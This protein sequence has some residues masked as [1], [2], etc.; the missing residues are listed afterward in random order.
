MLRLDPL[1]ILVVSMS[2]FNPEKALAA[3]AEND[4]SS[5]GRVPLAPPY[6]VVLISCS[7]LLAFIFLL[8]TCL[9]CKRGDVGFKEFE[10]PDGEEFSGEYTPPA[11][12]TSSSQSIPDVYILPLSEVSLPVSNTQAPKTVKQTGFSRQDL[13]YLQEIGNGW[14]GKVI[15]GEIFSDYTP[16]QVVVKELRVNASPLEQRKFLSEAQP[17]SLQ[18]SNILQCL[19]LCTETIPFLLIMEFCQLGDLKRYLRA[20]RKADGMTPDLLTCD[21]T[22]LQRMAYEITLGLMHL[23][24]NNYIHS[25]LA[26]RNC[27]LTS[28]L[29]VRIGDYGISHNNYKEDYY[30]T[31][32]RLWIPLR[33]VAP[34][35]LDEV[36]GNLVVVD[37]SKES[38]VWSLGV[39]MWELFEFGSQ[40]YRHLSDEEVLTFVIKEQQMKLAKPRLKLPHSDYWYEV[41][42]SCWLP[43]EQRPSVEELHLQL[44]YLLNECSNQT[45]ESFEWRWNAL[46]PT[47]TSG[48]PLHHSEEISAFPLLDNF[49]GGDGFHADMDDILTVTESSRG[50]NFEYM[51]EKARLG[52]WKATPQCQNYPPSNGGLTVPANPFYE[53]NH[54][55]S[56]QSLETPSVVPVISA[57]SPSVSSEY[58]IR[59]EE[60]TDRGNNVDCTV[61]A[62]SPIYERKYE[63]QEPRSLH[64]RLTIGSPASPIEPL[65]SSDWDPLESERT[66]PEDPPGHLILHEVPKLIDRW[67]PGNNNPFITV[68]RDLPRYMNPFRGPA[69]RD[70][71]RQVQETSLIEPVADVFSSDSILNVYRDIEDHRRSWDSDTMEERGAGETLAGDP[72]SLAE[73]LDDRASPWDCEPSLMED[74]SSESSSSSTDNSN[75]RNMPSCP[76]CSRGVMG[77]LQR[78]SCAML[79][80]DVVIDW[81]AHVAMHQDH[82]GLD[83]DS[84]LK[85]EQGSLSECSIP[86]RTFGDGDLFTGPFGDSLCPSEHQEF[87]DPLMGAAVKSYDIQDYRNRSQVKAYE[88]LQKNVSNHPPSPFIG[89]S[90]SMANCSVIVPIEIPPLSTLA[91]SME[92]EETIEISTDVIKRF[93]VTQNTLTIEKFSQNDSRATLDSVDSL[94]I[95]SNTSSSD[96]CSPSSHYSSP[97]QKFGDSGYETENTFSP[98][99]IFKDIKEEGGLRHVKLPLTPISESTSD[100]TLTE[101]TPE[102]HT[103][104]G[105]EDSLR[106]LEIGTPH[107]DSAYFSDYDNECEKHCRAAQQNLVAGSH[108]G[109]S[110]EEETTVPALVEEDTPNLE[111]APESKDIEITETSCEFTDEECSLQ[112][113]SM[114]DIPMDSKEETLNCNGELNNSSKENEPNHL[115]SENTNTPREKNNEKQTIIIDQRNEEDNTLKKQPESGFV[116]QV[117][118]EQLLVSLRENVT[119]NVLSTFESSDIVNSCVLKDQAVLKLW[120]METTA[121]PLSE[122]LLKNESMN[123]QP[124]EEQLEES[125]PRNSGSTNNMESA[126]ECGNKEPMDIIKEEP[127][128]PVQQQQQ[129]EAPRPEDKKDE[130]KQETFSETGIDLLE[131]PVEN[132]QDSSNETKE[133]AKLFLDFGSTNAGS[134][135]IKAKVARLSLSLPPLNLQAFQNPTG[136]KSLWDNNEE[137]ES[138][139]TKEE[140]EEEDG[141]SFQDQQRAGSESEGDVAGIPIVVSETDDGRNLRSLLKSPKSADEADDDLDRK[142]KM[143][144]FF[145][146]VT[147]YLFDQETPT[148]EL[149]NQS[150]A[151]GDQIPHNPNVD[152]TIDNFSSTDGFSGSF[153]WDDDFPLMTQNSSFIPMATEGAALKSHINPTSPPPPSTFQGKRVDPSLMDTLRFTRFTVSPAVDPHPVLETDVAPSAGIEN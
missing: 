17:Y 153:E 130:T 148:N 103:T 20:Q 26:L 147:V 105:D 13:S 2:Y 48:G 66:S 99:F 39:T 41:M 1:F 106:N 38:N 95:P 101:D 100:L 30:I 6:A 80:G 61:C 112:N 141:F 88:S 40:P 98:E 94:D 51:W 5:Q 137:W 109:F 121:N 64:Q 111:E 28:D 50:L 123:K 44:T 150:G 45:E 138:P 60:H 15:L 35:L 72:E 132:C 113:A 140:D 54:Q 85:V 108:N 93:P 84:S 69:D 27:L 152:P 127:E 42:Q 59:L 118:K 82:Y 46:K 53:S 34:E 58:Y 49:N 76:L 78:C 119:R 102:A 96:V 4:G 135:A 3:P 14:F 33:W 77:G 151:E 136:R 71:S 37:Q 22:T 52:R 131:Q 144:S 25:D 47:K 67:T 31:P 68:G 97:G 79:R 62:P 143:V 128:D 125:N 117:C 73:F 120:S 104:P 63:L 55:H 11:E 32:D 145:D 114:D 24:K 12:E 116:V 57:R 29:T 90:N 21:L 142:R 10:N 83:D 18:H 139:Q 146:D 9:C 56:R 124:S 8:L 110:K 43:T 134:E 75:R 91:E 129:E 65:F 19:G 87:Y 133:Q 122:S 92:E 89:I 107:R 74:Q 23:H 126:N 36:H 149:S 7:G 115:L 70:L 81:T 86:T 16:A